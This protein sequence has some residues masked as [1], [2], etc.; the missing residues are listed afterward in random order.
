M[1]PPI[2]EQLPSDPDD[3]TPEMENLELEPAD[4]TRKVQTR[5]DASVVRPI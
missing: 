3:E 5:T 4:K 2:P 1:A